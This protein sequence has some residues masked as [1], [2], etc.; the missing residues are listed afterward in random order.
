M[1]WLLTCAFL[2]FVFRRATRAREWFA[3][4]EPTGMLRSPL[5]QARTALLAALCGLMF[6]PGYLP[7]YRYR[8]AVACAPRIEV[9]LPDLD[10][11]S[12]GR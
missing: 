4:C 2:F 11:L 9:A 12:A 3:E 8:G 7:G 10:Y 5:F 1:G 6:A